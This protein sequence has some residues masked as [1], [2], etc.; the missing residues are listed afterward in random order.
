MSDEILLAGKLKKEV[1]QIM[2]VVPTMLMQKR[3]AW[4]NASDKRIAFL[5]KLGLYGKEYSSAVA[6][7]D[8]KHMRVF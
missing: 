8:R 2:D 3:M 4:V 6:K 7:Y 5:K 1:L